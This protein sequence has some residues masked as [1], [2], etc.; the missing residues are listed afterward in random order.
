M[1]TYHNR[2]T[3]DKR[4]VSVQAVGGRRLQAAELNEMQSIALYRD[5]Q[6]GDVIFGSGHII[7]GGQIYINET[8]TKVKISPSRVYLDGMIHEIPETTLDVRG[9]GEETIGLKVEYTNLT[10]RD[11]TELLDP[12]V[13]YSN[14]GLPGADRLIANPQWMA[15]DITATTMFRLQDGQ[16][17]TAKLPP[18]L[19]GFQP[20]LAR[21]THDTSG[22]FLVSGMDGFIEPRDTERVTLVVDAGKAYV[23]GY[24]ISKLVPLR[25]P[26]P[27]A[28]DT[29]LVT[30]ETKTFVSGTT[31]YALNSQPVKEIKALTA[32]IEVS[33]VITRG[34][35]AGTADTLPKTPVVDIVSVTAGATTYT[36]GTDYQLS[37]NTVDW[38]PNGQEPPG[39]TSYTVVYRY[40]KTMIPQTDYKLE[41][42]KVKFLSG[43]D[44]PVNGTTFQTTYEFYLARKD[45]YYLTAEGEI[46]LVQG[47]SAILPPSPSAPPDVLELG[48][49]YLP[50]NSNQV[51]VYNRKPKRLTMLELRSLLDRLERAEYNQAI[52]DLDRTAQYSDPTIQK[53]GIFTDNF[54]NFERADVTH[55]QFDAM[56]NP[57]EKVLQLPVE[58]ELV[59]LL[60]DR[61]A[62]N[63][64]IHERLTTID[65][66]EE[67]LIDQSFATETMNVNPYQVFGNLA[68][69]RLT[70]SHDSWVETSIVTRTVWD[71]WATWR[72]VERTETRVILDENVPFIRVRDVVVQAEG[73]EPNSDNIKA[74]FDGVDIALTPLDSSV[75]GTLPGTMKADANGRFSCKFTIPA[76][77]R[78]GTREVRFWNEV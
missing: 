5:K 72:S 15:N 34:N 14:Y 20:V 30:N 27:K 31:D 40:T 45:V 7:E 3:P 6:I 66:T 78:T 70:P 13:G 64:R 38:V 42:E 43:G 11:D 44:K 71:W 46:K 22:N 57:G 35:I 65:Y 36:K 21:R 12:A 33:A 55:P 77:I 54:T 8:K 19:E 47:Q 29:Q 37:G 2:F 17:L 9:T 18:E 61:A 24:E 32:T 41:N 53:K 10:Y 50:P 4:W 48:E 75:K 62:S 60:I 67:V 39:G 76:N 68:T 59:D 51:V 23:Q 16:L 52:N 49:L 63:V 26:I 73:F 25:I 1:T 58:Q 28:L 69:V 56:L 74:T